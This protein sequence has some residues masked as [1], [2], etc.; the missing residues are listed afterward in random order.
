MLPG[1]DSEAYASD[2]A[3]FTKLGLGCEILDSAHCQDM[4]PLI[5]MEDYDSA[6]T[7]A[8]FLET[9]AGY[10]NP[11]SVLADLG[12]ACR[13]AGVEMLFRKQVT[14]FEAADDERV[15][16]VVCMD[17]GEVH[18]DVFVSA[19][20]PWYTN[21]TLA[22]NH[23]WDIA[24]TRIQVVHKPWTC[25]DMSMSNLPITCDAL[26]G[27]YFRPDFQT[28]HVVV[29]TIL[30][31]EESERVTNPDDFNQ[32]A[33]PEQRTRYL[34]SLHE[35]IPT[36]TPRGSIKSY[37]ALYTL[38]FSDGHPIVGPVGQSA[39]WLNA[40]GFTGH[41]F[42]IAPA[43]GSMLAQM[44]TRVEARATP[45]QTVVDP[46]ALS[47]SRVRLADSASVLA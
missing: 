44:A 43:I 6:G 11:S 29:S 46:S 2:A 8:Y 7:E 14:S 37:S 45:F 40:T 25:P 1:M 31:E 28:D 5:S 30:P 18:G 33:D 4:Y 9:E 35:R 47:A 3:R 12:L 39:N 42:K 24:P 15:S 26:G 10:I 17:G 23:V 16:H 13:D 19:L 21:M 38:N 22:H 27:I 36:L 41:G 34:S 20:G 32:A